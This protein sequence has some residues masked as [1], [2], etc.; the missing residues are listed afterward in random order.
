[1]ANSM[2][3]LHYSREDES[4]ADEFGMKYMSQAAYD[5]QQMLG[6]MNVL[7][8]LEADTPGGE[9]EMLRTHPLATTRIQHVQDLLKQNDYSGQGRIRFTSGATLRQGLPAGGGAGDW[10]GSP[11]E[12]KGKDDW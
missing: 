6:V 12:P 1:M 8:K 11:V 3:Q 5:P 7:R 9:P 10:E 4:Q 2:L